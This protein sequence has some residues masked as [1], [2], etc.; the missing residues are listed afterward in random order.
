MPVT[1]P[2]SV[3][4]KFVVDAVEVAKSAVVALPFKEAVIVPAEKF[5]EA[6]LLT[7][8][9]AVLRDVELFARVTPEA[10][11]EDD[12]PPTVETTVALWIPVTSPEREPEKLVDVIEEVEEV[13]FPLREAVMVPAEKLPEASLVT[14]A[15]GVL[16]DV[17]EVAEFETFPVVVIVASFVSTIAADVETSAFV[18]RE[19]DKLPEALL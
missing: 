18:I 1:S 8:V 7:I 4:V 17:A 11:L 13:A 5:P 16:D 6:S 10:T 3:P 19:E 14:I 9:D 2:D 15:D 12:I